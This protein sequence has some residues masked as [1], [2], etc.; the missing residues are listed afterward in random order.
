MTLFPLMGIE[1]IY[2]ITYNLGRHTSLY[3]DDMDFA[4]ARWL[5]KRLAREFDD[6]KKARKEA[7]SNRK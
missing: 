3:R 1:D 7:L 5:H 4:E 6:I 2:E